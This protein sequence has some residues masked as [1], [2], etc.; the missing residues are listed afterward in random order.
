[1]YRIAQEAV[2][3]AVRH[4]SAHAIHIAL[5]EGP[6]QIRLRVKDDGE[7]FQPG[8]HDG[9][10]MGMRIMNYRARIIGGVLEVTSRP[11]TGTTITCTVPRNAYAD[12]EREAVG[13]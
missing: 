10:G 1:M 5:A 7:G 8:N 11:G 2:S 9:P 3:N 4:G 13:V 6:D 12:D